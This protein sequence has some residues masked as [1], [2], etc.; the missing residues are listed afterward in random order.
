[1]KGMKKLSDYL[2]DKKVPLSDKDSIWLLASGNNIVWVVGYRIDE[3][4]RITPETRQIL[5]IRYKQQSR[6]G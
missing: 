6:T 5:M 1:M 2:I 4:F 3:R